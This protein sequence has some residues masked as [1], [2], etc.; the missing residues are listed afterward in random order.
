M[1]KNFYE[2]S[3]LKVSYRLVHRTE[4]TSKQAD[5]ASEHD[6]N[7]ETWDTPAITG[8]CDMFDGE[9]YQSMDEHQSG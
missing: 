3:S 8:S 1:N 2:R 5:I 7:T 4:G 9:R 6:N